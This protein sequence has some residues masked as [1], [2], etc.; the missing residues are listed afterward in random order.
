MY[1]YR[2]G[3]CTFTLIYAVRD[4]LLTDICFISSIIYYH[5]SHLVRII[6]PSLK[7]ILGNN[8]SGRIVGE[9]EID[10]IRGL[11]RYL[12]HE[13]VF[14][15][16]RHVYHIGPCLACLIKNAGSSCHYICVNIH[17]INRITDCNLTILCEDFLYISAVALC[18]VRNKDFIISYITASCPVVILGSSFSQKLISQIRSISMKSLSNSHLINSLVK[19]IYDNRC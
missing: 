2:A 4:I 11:C 12:G 7:S 16:T 9:A 13:I 18:T 6:N 5:R 14:S 3:P 8:S 17:G 10:D 1:L 19:G 15:R